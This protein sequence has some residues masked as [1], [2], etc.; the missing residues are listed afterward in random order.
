M[1]SDTPADEDLAELLRQA[2]GRF[3]RTTR[4]HADTLPPAQA[5]ALGALDHGGP[6]TIAQLAAARG[7]KHQS[8]SRTVGELEALG[9]VARE[10]SPS[11]G[12]AFVIT[13][14][15]A[16]ATALDADREARRHWVAGAIATRLSPA[17]REILHAVPALLDRL[18]AAGESA[19]PA[20]VSRILAA[21]G[22]AAPTLEHDPAADGRDDAEVAAGGSS[23]PPVRN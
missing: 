18:S 4:A 19:V 14:T 8:M 15:A 12:R 17:E 20:L 16:G 11:D 6:R 23:A 7:V 10:R 21:K 5:T 22:R 3:V 13:L 1:T 2:I 9:L